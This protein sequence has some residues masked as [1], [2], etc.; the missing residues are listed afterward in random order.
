MKQCTSRQELLRNVQELCFACV[1][2]NL[3]LDNNPDDK[4]AI[5]TYNTL[6]VKFAQAR[7]EYESKYGPLTNFGY[8]PSKYPWQ[9]V[10]QPWPW[11]REFNY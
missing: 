5:N 2:M 8:A 7:C 9:W 10:D 3:Y 6:T 1:D 11:D 4:N